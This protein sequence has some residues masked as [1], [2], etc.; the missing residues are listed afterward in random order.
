MFIVLQQI[1]ICM[2]YCISTLYILSKYSTTLFLPCITVFLFTPSSKMPSFCCIFCCVSHVCHAQV[3]SSNRFT[4]VQPVSGHAYYQLCPNMSSMH[5]CC[6]AYPG[7]LLLHALLDTRTGKSPRKC[8][9]GTVHGISF[10]FFSFVPTV[11]LLFF[12]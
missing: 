2:G 11:L 8:Q 1:T 12:C 5:S 3:S 10:F 4:S 6:N 7:I 9:Q